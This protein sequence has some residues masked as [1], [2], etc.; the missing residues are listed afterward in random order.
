MNNE[1]K[2]PIDELK[3]VWGEF[4]AGPKSLATIGWPILIPI[5]SLI[6]L[7]VLVLHAIL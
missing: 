4:L 2:G 1:T 3:D 6:G 7:V 5:V